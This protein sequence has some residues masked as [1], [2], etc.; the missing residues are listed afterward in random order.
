MNKAISSGLVELVEGLTREVV[1]MRES[2]ADVPAPVLLEATHSC[3]CQETQALILAELKETNELLRGALIA[4][5]ILR[6]SPQ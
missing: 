2:I 1:A 6:V 5:G 3:P 4:Q